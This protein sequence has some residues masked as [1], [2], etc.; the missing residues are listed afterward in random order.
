M[1]S[2]TAQ[3]STLYLR[4][5]GVAA[6]LETELLSNVS[7]LRRVGKTLISHHLAQCS[8]ARFSEQKPRRAG[9]RVEGQQ[10]AGDHIGSRGGDLGLAGMN[11]TAPSLKRE[12]VGDAR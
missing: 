12:A 3:L 11:A 10:T 6:R 8:E 4:A 9:R 5:D 2:A 7:K 1:Q